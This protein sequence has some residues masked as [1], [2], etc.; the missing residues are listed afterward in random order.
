MLYTRGRYKS[1]GEGVPSRACST[2]KISIELAMQ[3][4]FCNVSTFF[5]FN[6]LIGPYIFYGFER[7]R[8]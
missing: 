7:K 6:S 3:I 5:I 2:F 1:G 4:L 8:G